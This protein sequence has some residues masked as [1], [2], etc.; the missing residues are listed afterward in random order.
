MGD[1]VTSGLGIGASVG[2][3]VAQLAAVKDETGVVI[4]QVKV[5]ANDIAEA[6]RL[7]MKKKP[8]LSDGYQSRVEE[9]I[10][11]T[12]LAVDRIAKEVEP[13]RKSV[14]K[15]GT[16]NVVDRIDWILRRSGSTETYQHSLETCHRSLLDRIS[17]LRDVQPNTN[18]H[19]VLSPKRSPTESHSERP[20][21]Q[22]DSDESDDGSYTRSSSPDGLENMRSIERS[23]SSNFEITSTTAVVHPE[24]AL[25]EASQV[26]HTRKFKMPKSV[27]HPERLL[28]EEMQKRYTKA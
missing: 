10:R 7:Y 16:V 12:R 4:G 24:R 8:Y 15:V 6:E 2:R 28:Y 14:V 17:M 25:Y 20:Q 13:A 11:S 26:N 23:A 27:V 9:V 18:D 19:F 1:A 22:S 3:F 5:V 21:V